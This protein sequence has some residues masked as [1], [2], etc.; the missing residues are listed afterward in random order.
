M[1]ASEYCPQCG[2][3][4]AGAFRFCRSCQFDFDAVSA[5]PPLPSP[6]AA[7]SK[8]AVPA[9]IAPPGPQVKGRSQRSLFWGLLFAVGFGLWAFSRIYPSGAGGIPSVPVTDTMAGWH[10][11]LAATTCADY[12]GSMTSA[13]QV[14]AAQSLLAILRRQEVSDASAGA[15][16]AGLF[17]AEIGAACAKY[18]GS[19]P[20]T[21]VIA[22]AT[23]A[24]INDPS[25]H[26]AHH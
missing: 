24:W 12:T 7:Q 23:M 5:P 25:L 9:P 15:E 2:T 19:A 13:Q 17:A 10:T 11:N 21:G 18:Y 20:T 6:T 4:R 3:V 8:P 26:P 14:A 22:G 16:F 1:M